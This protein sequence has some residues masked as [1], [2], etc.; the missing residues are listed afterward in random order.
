[1]AVTCEPSSSRD[2]KPYV[3][4]TLASQIEKGD[5]VTNMGLVDGVT[6]DGVF[7]ICAIRGTTWNAVTGTGAVATETVAWHVT[8]EVTLD[9][10]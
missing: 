5:M 7:V 9:R 2:G 1:M 10:Q 4:M 8:N 3:Y 6:T